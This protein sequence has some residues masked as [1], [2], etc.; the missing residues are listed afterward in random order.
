MEPVISE[1]IQKE[2]KSIAESQKMAKLMICLDFVSSGR[3]GCRD[4]T[5][6]SDDEC[7]VEI[8]IDKLK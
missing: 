5:D 6:I 7:L 4:A 8:L 3:Y 2:M 1:R